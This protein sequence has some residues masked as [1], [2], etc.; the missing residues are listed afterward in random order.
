MVVEVPFVLFAVLDAVPVHRAAHD[1]FLKLTVSEPG[2]MAAWALL[3]KGTLGVLAS[4]P[5]P[6][7]PSRTRCSPASS[8]CGRR[9]SSQTA[10]AVRYSPTW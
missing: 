3:A 7:P 6:R 8:D 10:T 5:W 9:A 2:L 1:H 4:S